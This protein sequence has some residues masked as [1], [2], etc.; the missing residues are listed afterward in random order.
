MSAKQTG[1]TFETAQQVVRES[2]DAWNRR[3]TNEIPSAY[4]RNTVWRYRNTF[5]V[6]RENIVPFLERYWPK[7]QNYKLKKEL[8]A[9][10]D[11]RISVRFQ[12]EWKNGS[13]GQ[14]YRTY[15]N[16]HWE[17]DDDGKITILD[18]SANDMEIEEKDRRFK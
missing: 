9:F 14:W 18:L 10:T 2:E 13:T 11:V 16:E 8:W 7:Q 5:F 12:S 3:V 17:F 6:G 1:F 4:S 15:G